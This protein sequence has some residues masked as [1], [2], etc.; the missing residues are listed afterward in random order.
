MSGTTIPT[1]IALFAIFLLAPAATRSGETDGDGKAMILQAQRAVAAY[2]H[3][4]RRSG[5]MPRVVYFVP[6]DIDPLPAYRQRLGRVMDDVDG[7][8]REGLKRFG[9]ETDGLPLDRE[10]GR[11]V[12]HLVR[13]KLPAGQYHYSSGE[14]ARAEIRDA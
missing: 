2:H 6:K 8:F 1:G 12:L 11:V 10:G 3:G 14:V 13:G 9:L 4:S 7:F 5:G